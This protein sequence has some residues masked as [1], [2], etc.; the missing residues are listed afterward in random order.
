MKTG[1]LRADSLDLERA[2]Q[3][4]VAG[5]LVAFP[6]E[7]VYG[8]GA[9]AADE[10]A[11]RAVFRAKGRP[12]DH[13]LI[14]HLAAREQLRDWTSAGPDLLRMA[15][16]LASHL[17]PGPLTLVLPRSEL[18]ADVVT[19]GQDTVALRMPAHPVA[20]ALL[21]ASGLALVAPSAN[22]FGRVSPTSASHVLD[23]LDGRIHFVIDGGP[24]EVGLESTIV[25]LSGA[26]PRVLRPGA[27]TPERLAEVLGQPVQGGHQAGAPRVSGSL[28]SHYAPTTR[29]RLA[30]GS[31]LVAAAVRHGSSA[32]VIALRAAPADF[33]GD[34]RQLPAEP[35]GY[36]RLLYATLRELDGQ[37]TVILVEEPPTSSDWEA[38]RDR[39]L[40]ASAGHGAESEGQDG[41]G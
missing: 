10:A 25:D 3:A 5:E 29:T 23:E 12:A 15:E 14:V 31:E 1:L 9:N 24:S 8:L 22:R 28:A 7:T 13:P 2:A 21:Q 16:L 11:V 38:V 34:W 17:W 18:A 39:L 27:V 4:L 19:G 36:A 6:T 20:R 30:A 37:V 40:R 32:G 41:S 35:A 26:T 33:R